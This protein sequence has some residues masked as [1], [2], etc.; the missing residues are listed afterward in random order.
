[1]DRITIVVVD[2][3]PLF[4]E[5]VVGSL[6]LEPD[7]L[8]VG[9]AADGARGLEL[10]RQHRPLVAIVDVNLPQLNGH[11]VTRM[12]IAEK[13]PTRII[14]LTAYDDAEQAIH[15]MRAGAAAYCTK[16]IQ[17]DILLGIVR[18]VAGGKF[19]LG[20]QEMDGASLERWLRGQSESAMRQYSD[21]GDPFEP[22]SPREM[23]V[24]LCLTRGMS[25]KEIAIE[26]G[27][28]HQT[29]K[30]HL[31]A[32]LRKL[33]VGD[34]TQAALYA[35]RQGWVRLYNHSAGNEE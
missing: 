23:E 31:T 13:I 7:F 30:N 35:L 20:S 12:A 34:R 22:L 33:G 17:P 28:S 19:I 25:N 14:L 24:L 9:Q 6:T 29:V 26:L 18:K 21:P 11:Q 27:I 8:V 16:D 32:I 1:M 5:G 4:R 10:I 3:H 15:A 2:D